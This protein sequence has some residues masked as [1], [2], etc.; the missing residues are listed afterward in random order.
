MTIFSYHLV[1]LP[2]ITALS[3]IV[4][5]PIPKKTPGLI[6]SE[7]MTVMTLGS[8]V[9]SRARMLVGQVAVFM[10]WDD[11]QSLDDFLRSDSFG[12]KLASGWHLRLSFMREWGSFTGFE[13]PVERAELDSPEASVV[14]VTVARMKPWAVPRF[15]RWGRPVEMQ[16]RDDPNTTLSLASI[17]IPNT[18]S[19]FS[20]WNSVKNMT[21]MVHGHSTVDRPERHRD[22]MKERDRKDFHF[23]FTTLRFRP[24]SEHGT[25]KGRSHYVPDL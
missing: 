13:L 5:S 15:I 17:K 2:F 18:V 4:R 10:Q 3:G 1:E 12:Q 19:T 21:N 7:Y 6:H 23:E 20:I 9:F 11:E 16:V 24:L 25:W 8:P 22:A 14:A